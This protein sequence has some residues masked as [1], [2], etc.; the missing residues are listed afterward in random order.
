MW[1]LSIS[2][3]LIFNQELY[4]TIIFHLLFSDLFDEGFPEEFSFATTYRLASLTRMKTWNLIDIRDRYDN[5]QFA[6]QFDGEREKKYIS[7]VYVDKYD[8]KLKTV[9]F[10]ERRNRRTY[11]TV[12]EFFTITM[13]WIKYYSKN[14]I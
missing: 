12:S 9:S 11:R 8:N 14:E 10:D 5:T 3:F 4:F 2:S 6:I 7:V 13:S 1:P